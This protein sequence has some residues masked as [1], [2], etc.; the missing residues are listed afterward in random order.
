MDFLEFFFPIKGIIH[1]NCKDFLII[2]K[3]GVFGTYKVEAAGKK[4]IRNDCQE[5]KAREKGKERVERK[6]PIKYLTKEAYDFLPR[7]SLKWQICIFLFFF[8]IL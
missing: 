7:F 3:N 5:N 4:I 6:L 1:V 2:L 8:S